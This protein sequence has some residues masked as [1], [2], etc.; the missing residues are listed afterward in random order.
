L[1][2]ATA[3]SLCPVPSSLPIPPSWPAVTGRPRL[4]MTT[5]DL[6]PSHARGG[7]CQCEQATFRTVSVFQRPHP[8]RF[9]GAM[10]PSYSQ[11]TD[12]DKWGVLGGEIDCHFSSPSH[13]DI[14]V[15]EVSKIRFG[16]Q[17]LTP[18]RGMAFILHKSRPI[19]A[20]RQCVN[21]LFCRTLGPWI[22]DTRWLRKPPTT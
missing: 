2:T 19:V 15:S 3:F 21:E 11:P 1:E 20:G 8:I 4:V 16:L 6:P 18:S 17:V 22:S 5:Q 7:G 13:C 10:D 12:K 9:R 14:A